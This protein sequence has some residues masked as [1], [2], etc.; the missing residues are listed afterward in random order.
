MLLHCAIEGG[1]LTPR[2]FRGCCAWEA[3]LFFNNFYP[4]VHRFA[5][6]VNV[7]RQRSLSQ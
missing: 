4:I 2:E 3:M 6:H 1:H 5:L 7:I